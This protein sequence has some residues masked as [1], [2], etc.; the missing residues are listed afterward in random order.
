MKISVQDFNNPDSFEKYVPILTQRL[1]TEPDNPDIFTAL[2]AIFCRHGKYTEALDF[3]KRSIGLKPQFAGNYV[4]LS[5]VYGALGEWE[6]AGDVLR[7]GLSISENVPSLYWN[8]SLH[9]LQHDQWEKGWEYYQYRKVHLPGHRRLLQPEYD[10]KDSPTG[11]T[12]LIWCEQGLGDH[13]MMF[14]FVKEAK[15]RLGFQNVIFECEPEMTGLFQNNHNGEL[16]IVYSRSADFNTPFEFDEHLSIMDLPRYFQLKSI[17]EVDGSPFINPNPLCQGAWK[18]AFKDVKGKKIGICW[19]G[20]PSHPNDF[21]RSSTLKDFQ[22]LEKVG[23]IISLV[24]DKR[25]CDTEAAKEKDLLDA[26]GGFSNVDALGACLAELDVVVTVDTLVAH[27][28]GAMGIE[29]YLLLPYANEWRWQFGDGSTKWYD[30]VTMIKQETAGDWSKPI[31][32]C[33][34][35]LGPQ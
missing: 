34:T 8:Y 22:Q 26:S 2:A 7:Y 29:T 19:C 14:R 35:L 20:S 10:P 6:K 33:L 17:R 1:I 11:K 28:A 9:L 23:T 3:C 30:S 18:E 27:L 13:I 12:L 16:D 5:G 31:E 21:N 25:E 15:E 4:A 32:K 24:R